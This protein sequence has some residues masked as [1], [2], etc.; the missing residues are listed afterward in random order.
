VPTEIVYVDEPYLSICW[1]AGSQCLHQEWKGFANSVEFRSGQTRLLAAIE[2]SCTT[3]LVS[4]TRKLELITT[5][6]QLWIRDTWLPLAAAA[7]LKRIALLVAHRGLGKF[8]LD[9]MQKQV[10]SQVESQAGADPSAF[11]SREF[12]SVDEATKWADAQAS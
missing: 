7:G 5:E 4:D 9:E 6:D 11:V 2:N 3:A 12:D 8:A 1:R 10:R